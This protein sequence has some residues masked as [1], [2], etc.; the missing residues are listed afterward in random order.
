MNLQ[1][2]DDFFRWIEE[3]HNENPAVLR[4]KW[5]GRPLPFD[6][7]AAL[8]Q[9]ECRKKCAGKLSDT[10][11]TSPRFYFPSIL[12]AEQSTSDRLASFHSSNY[13]YGNS[14]TIHRSPYPFVLHLKSPNIPPT[15]PAYTP[16]PRFPNLSSLIHFS[17]P[18]PYP[19][20]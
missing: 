19:S 7:D 18:H 8:I 17:E 5:A 15:L 9:I 13:L 1:F 4:L 12:S 16:T 20:L 10:L 3:H 2:N 11:G 14:S 6:L